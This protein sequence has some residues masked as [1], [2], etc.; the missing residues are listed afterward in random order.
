MP[1]LLGTIVS[2]L[3]A[4]RPRIEIVAKPSGWQELVEMVGRKEVAVVVL[5]C[6]EDEL[7]GLGNRL[8]REHSL[9]KILAVTNDGR[10]A[11][12]YELWPRRRPLAETSPQ[13]LLD[14]IEE[15]PDW[16]CET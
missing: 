1:R 12:H 16:F 11:S 5:G 2:Q 13:S 6:E 10:E 9:L 7:V 14:A 15:I 8:L 3:A 4:S